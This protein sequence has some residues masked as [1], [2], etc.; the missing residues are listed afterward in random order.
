MVVVARIADQNVEHKTGERPLGVIQPRRSIGRVDPRPERR[1]GERRR[2]HRGDARDVLGHLGHKS[3]GITE[4]RSNEPEIAVVV[5][6]PFTHPQPLGRLRVIVAIG[7][8]VG[9]AQPFH[10]PRV[11]H[12]VR[13]ESI[14]SRRIDATTRDLV[15]L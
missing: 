2:G 3:G 8:Q 4:A 7:H 15:H 10:V 11:E 9:G 5:G 14:E 12:L 6:D 1:I 13:V